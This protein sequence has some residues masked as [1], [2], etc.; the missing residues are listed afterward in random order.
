MALA[1]GLAF[2]LL[3]LCGAANATNPNPW[4][5]SYPMAEGFALSVRGQPVPIRHDMQDHP[6]VAIAAADL[7]SDLGM[8]T[9]GDPMLLGSDDHAGSRQE[10]W[11]GTLGRSRLI[12]ALVAAGRV[13]VGDLAGAWES[14]VITSVT[15]PAPG[16][17][18][19]LLIIG[20]DR[21]GTAYGAYELS[22]AIGVSPWVWWA[23]VVPAHRPDLYIAAGIRRF[24]PP[25]VKYR[26]IFIND[27]D[28]GL[29]PW[30]AGTFD[31]ERGDIG[32]KTYE[33][34]FGLLLR[35]RAN[36]LWPAMHQVTQAF[37]ADPANARLADRYAII[38]G[39][40][41][42]EPMLRNNV[43]EWKGP[44]VAYDYAKNPALVSEYWRDRLRSNGGFE[45][46]YTLGMRGIHDSGIVGVEG[47]EAQR[48]LLNR[49]IVDQ[50]RL[51]AE[52]VSPEVE[53][54]P[55]VFTPYKEVLALYRAG[56]NLPDDVTLVW[57]D[58]NFG[59]IRQFP[60]AAERARAGGSG[61]YYHL[62]YLG[63]PLSHLWLS[64]VP[65]SLIALEM[66]RAYDLGA[67]TLWVANVGDI[68]P[69][70][71]NID[72]FTSMG[73][74]MEGF[75][76]AGGAPGFLRDWSAR[77]F[78]EALGADVADILTR[79]HRLNFERKPEHL[80]WWLPG[81]RPRRS[82]LT[83][84]HAS[85]RLAAFDQLVA[86]LDRVQPRVPAPLSDAF[87]QLVEYPVRAAALANQR[88]FKTEAYETLFNA[89][90]VTARKNGAEAR[91]ADAALKALTARY[92]GEIAGGK[93]RGIMAEEPA[94]SLWRKYRLSPPVL[95][96]ATLTL[97]D[98]ADEPVPSGAAPEATEIVRQAE[99]FSRA[100]AAADATWTLVPDLGRGEGAMA[101]APVTAPMREQGGP[102][103]FY[104]LYLPP[105]NW[106]LSLDLIPTFPVD[107]GEMMRLGLS[108][109]GAAA[110]TVE[111]VR[112]TGDDGWVQGVL[113]GR[114]RQTTGVVLSGGR[115]ML[116]LEMR[117][118]GPVIDAV[119]LR[120]VAAGD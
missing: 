92:N 106:S 48:T 11:I 24:G 80:Q 68:K 83:P 2:C 4:V 26:G 76:R 61:V 89:K 84:A 21:R 27:E 81:E 115:H 46:V 45:N 62:S 118:A 59:Y 82:D 100:E 94:D 72:L 57:P 15:D 90:P 30:A 95:P 36:L 79:H 12:D 28:W 55:Q 56:L 14:F 20:S 70:E 69:A 3:L 23:D 111:V 86:D 108:V 5:S 31:P 33:K 67:R 41:H 107:G 42:A 65:P 109:D 66:G 78:G 43:G 98:R 63:A 113:D 52:N 50:R 16:V 120:R 104:E 110:V 93:W 74:D 64:T 37:N 19:A 58:D 51:L 35:L 47:V 73:W 71:T 96:A 116:R 8:V 44:A 53:R 117:D 103:L 17:K 99:A 101:V 32:P 91:A 1:Q 105:G 102:A 29:H 97:P 88:Y 38:M 85:E 87:F 39:S 22:R 6:V 114:V 75:R 9:G 10:V 40:S 18:K 7:A 25:S 13:Q 60:N 77:T 54:L 34:V 112:V 49:I 119:I